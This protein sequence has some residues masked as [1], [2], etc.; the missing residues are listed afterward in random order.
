MK[1]K[2][3]EEGKHFAVKERSEYEIRVTDE[4]YIKP[5]QNKSP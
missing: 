3:L 5:A 4:S 1:A 2:G